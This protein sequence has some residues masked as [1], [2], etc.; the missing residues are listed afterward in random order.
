MRRASKVFE[1]VG[2]ETIRKLRE[3]VKIVRGEGKRP[4]LNPLP[5]SR[6]DPP[7]K[8]RHRRKPRR[9]RPDADSDSSDNY[10]DEG[11]ESAGS[12]FDDKPASSPK[13]GRKK[14]SKPRLERRRSHDPSM[15]WERRQKRGVKYGAARDRRK[16]KPRKLRPMGP[17]GDA[18]SVASDKPPRK[19]TK[20][21]PS[22]LP[23]SPIRPR[24]PSGGG[25]A[26]PARQHRSSSK[27]LNEDSPA[28]LEKEEKSPRPPRKAGPTYQV[29]A[30][31][32]KEEELDD[33]FGRKKPAKPRPARPRVA[34]RKP[35]A[36]EQSEEPLPSAREPRPR[37]ASNSAIPEPSKSAAPPKKKDASTN[38]HV[39][40]PASEPKPH[41]PEDKDVPG[42]RMKSALTDNSGPRTGIPL[43]K[44]I[45]S[46]LPPSGEA[47]G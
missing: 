4:Q 31:N 45:V 20:P 5:T 39:P 13:R 42:P 29:T 6:T 26:H 27:D 14:E 23:S 46:K 12:S 44:S 2:T 40:M 43:P 19:P 30:G 47:P 28:D 25:Y 10:D 34:A 3:Q 36:P 18:R 24:E 37:Q 11:F 38:R 15:S 17:D 7:S 9:R 33:F 32:L 8:H 35:P 21:K 41:E 22:R 16:N 1:Q